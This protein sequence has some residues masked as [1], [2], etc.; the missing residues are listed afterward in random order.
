[1]NFGCQVENVLIECHTNA[2]TNKPTC[3][4]LLSVVRGFHLS[5]SS[6]ASVHVSIISAL[7]LLSKSCQ[8]L[9]YSKG[10]LLE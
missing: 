3:L 9:C 6:L 10:V 2:T 5:L 1:M 8:N 4:A 7:V